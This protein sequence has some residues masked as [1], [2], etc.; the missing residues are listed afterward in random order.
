MHHS[1]SEAKIGKEINI[2]LIGTCNYKV[3][4]NQICNFDNQLQNPTTENI[5]K[6]FDLACTCTSLQASLKSTKIN[7]KVEL[8]LTYVYER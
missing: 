2:C 8:S 3:G 5:K 7:I 6:T 1:G 4:K